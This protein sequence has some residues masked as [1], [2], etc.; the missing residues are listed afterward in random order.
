MEAPLLGLSQRALIQLNGRERV[1]SRREGREVLEAHHACSAWILDAIPDG[2]LSI[3]RQ[4]RVLS[5]NRQ[6]E[7]LFA[8]R[9]KE[10]VGQSINKVFP[11]WRTHAAGSRRSRGAAATGAR[12]GSTS[13]SARR[14]PRTGCV[15]CSWGGLRPGRPASK[16]LTREMLE[17]AADPIWVTD[18]VVWRVTYAN[19]GLLHR[20]GYSDYEVL[21]RPIGLIAPEWADGSLGR[22][23]AQL[24]GGTASSVVHTTFLRCSDGVDVAVE[25]RTDDPAATGDDTDR[26]PSAYVSVARELTT[27]AGTEAVDELR[28]PA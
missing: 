7:R 19:S 28:H 15:P 13:V 22:K 17:T 16:D 2:V 9:R 23:L 26:G 1:P 20:L 14:A 24:G 3:D 11:L 10:L 8:Y 21:G 27:L 18:A 25:V 6:M 12:C 5:L 4:G